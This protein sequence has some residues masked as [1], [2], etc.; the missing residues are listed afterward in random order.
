M[1]ET[2]VIIIPKVQ[3]LQLHNATNASLTKG[4]YQFMKENQLDVIDERLD[5]FPPSL[6][7]SLIRKNDIL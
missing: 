7:N 1:P 5:L 2:L 3:A 6:A 4:F